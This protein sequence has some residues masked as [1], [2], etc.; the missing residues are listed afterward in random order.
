MPGHHPLSLNEVAVPAVALQVARQMAR[1]HRFELPPHLV[2]YYPPGG[3]LWDTLQ[4]WF[5]SVAAPE[6]REKISAASEAD[7]KFWETPAM[8]IKLIERAVRE[9]RARTPTGGRLVFCHNDL[10]PGNLI[11]D[12]TTGEIRIID[13]EYG[14]INYAAFDVANHLMEY[15]GGADEGNLVQGIPEYDRLPGPDAKRAFC[16]AYLAASQAE[17]APATDAAAVEAFVAEVE[18]FTPVDN[19]Y[20]GL[21]GVN[22]AKAEGTAEFPYM[23]YGKTRIERGLTDGGFL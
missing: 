3:S 8:D 15:C 21:W 18:F 4:E 13:L 11:L 20:W 1:L 23:L 17:G 2:P 22:Q 10:L 5:D 6:T 14:G 7:A 19:L 9:L 12:D 16:E